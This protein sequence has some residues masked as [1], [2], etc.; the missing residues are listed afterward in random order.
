MV[1]NAAKSLPA[2]SAA[3]VSSA[4]IFGDPM[5][6]TAVAGVPAAKTKIICH[7]GDNICKGGDFILAAHLS[8]GDDAGAAAAFAAAGT[9]MA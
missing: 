6:G 3:L 7:S 8:Y 2:A 5:N 9:K 4:I 1:H